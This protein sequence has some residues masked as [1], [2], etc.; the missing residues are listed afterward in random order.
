M[1]E[2]PNLKK[3][4]HKEPEEFPDEQKKSLRTDLN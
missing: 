3:S 2:K 1:T 4:G